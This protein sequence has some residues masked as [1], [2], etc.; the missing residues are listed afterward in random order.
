MKLVRHLFIVLFL[1]SPP[2]IAGDAYDGEFFGYKIGE[3]YLVKPSGT[4]SLF[5][6]LRDAGGT[7]IF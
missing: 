1:F 4:E 5:C 3:K 6:A 2:A 7:A